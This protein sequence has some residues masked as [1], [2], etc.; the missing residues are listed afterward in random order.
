MRTHSP[1]TILAFK[2][3]KLHDRTVNKSRSLLSPAAII[4]IFG[5]L[6]A[7]AA[8]AS[9]SVSAS[10]KN[11]LSAAPAKGA[12][13]VTKRQVR[14]SSSTLKT[15][16]GS[17]LTTAAFQ[18]TPTPTPTPIPEAIATYEVVGHA[19]TNIPKTN[20]VLGDEVCA[21]A[22]NAP[23]G[24]PAVRRFSWVGTRGFV[25]R[26]ADV[27]ANPD[28]DIFPLPTNDTSVIAGETVD[29]RGTWLV[30]LNST[31][32]NTTRTAAYFTVSDPDHQAADLVVYNFSTE[33]DPV[34]PGA[35][36]TSFFLSVSNTGPDTADNVHVTMA[37]PPDLNFTTASTSSA[38]SCAESAGVVDCSLA[39]WAS[40]AF[41][42]I[43][44]NFGVSGAAPNGVISTTANIGSDINDPRPASNSS[45][46]SVEVRS[47][48]AAPATCAL[49]CPGDIVVTA[50][51]PS[52][53]VVNFNNSVEVSGDCGTITY[54]PVSGSTFAI[55]DTPVSVTSG[56]GSGGSCSFTV[57]VIDPNVSPAPTVDCPLPDLTGAAGSGQGSANVTVTAPNAAGA[58]IS[59]VGVR[60]DSQIRN[61]DGTFVEDLGDPYPVGTTIIT[62]TVTD[63]FQRTA[64][65]TQRVI[66]TSADFPTIQ[67]PLADVNLNAGGTCAAT[68]TI[69]PPTFGGAGT[70]LTSRRND[71]LPLTA[72]FQAGQ[73]IITWTA[74]NDLG[75]ASCIQ[76]VN[77][78]NTG[79][80]SAAPILTVPADVDVT[81]NACSA[82]LDDE[83][84]VATATDVCASSVN[85]SR[86]GVPTIPCPILGN[87]TRVCETFVFP[88]GTTDVTYTAT[89]SAGLTATGVQHVTVRNT[90]PPVF[91][92]VPGSVGPINNDA[93]LCGAFVGDA[94]LGTATV[95]DICDTGVIRSGVPAGNIFPV[96]DTTITY[97]AKADLSVTGTQHVIVVDNTLPV[98]TPP[99]AV[100]LYTGAGATSCGVTV[101]NLD[102]TLGTASAT[103]NCPALSA[104][105]R[106]GVPAGNFFPVGPTTLT[107]S[108]TDASNN[109]GFATQ[110]VTV[111]DNTPPVFTF[112]PPTVVA[113]TGPGATSC[114]TVISDATLGTA[115]ATDNCTVT[116]T[117]SPSGNTFPVGNTIVTWTATDGANPANTVTAT[118]TVTVIDNT[119][120]VIT[121]NGSMP[122]MW[123]PNHDYQTFQLTDFVT[124][125]TDNCGGISISNVVIEKV[126]SDEVE[127][128][129][130]DGN[131]NADIIIAAG[132]KSV[133]LRA[134]RAGGGDGRVY[135][136]TFKVTDTHG[137]VGRATSKV[138]V[139]HNPGETPVDS[140]V[141]YTVTGS[142]P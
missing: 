51:S 44:L 121:V 132:C 91:T 27:T 78:S 105:T 140:G 14:S 63:S 17:S 83:L 7:G 49:S 3:R 129:I 111:V 77:V 18:A 117:R 85:I 30:S 46:A 87:P 103:D 20:F 106:S 48:G 96:G 104:I 74:T 122:S 19:C 71:D 123:P 68:A 42:T 43:T 2:T 28:S 26:T 131:T 32:D 76:I 55:G 92:F 31:A 50:T 13:G 58:G 35:P 119:V 110:L 66:V 126:T 116:V 10:R 64:S 90:S 65:C 37:V 6:V 115:T 124:G 36:N 88:V 98:V 9:F 38:F 8:F 1:S 95:A 24:S 21:K 53:A 139:A 118:Q 25:R 45:V 107:Y 137:N 59:L 93:G 33:S 130:G 54:S 135:T 12:T 120:P 79:N 62:W 75:T 41:A 34:S 100:T 73:T 52:G 141:H 113:Y 84:G 97:K 23:F 16:I 101:A 57:T 134:E 127:N 5:L 142:C 11:P 133:Q 72:P 61:E 89:N 109:T 47:A 136:I 22:T 60:S 40:G 108:V 67:C 4:V 15:A 29:H 81:V 99:A 69:T 128:G 56:G 80:A 70:V 86:T 112:V 82:L 94:T 114:D 102:A 138:V 125:A 39:T